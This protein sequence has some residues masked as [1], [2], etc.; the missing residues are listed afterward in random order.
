MDILTLNITDKY[1]PVGNFWELD[2]AFAGRGEWETVLTR[3]VE[4]TETVEVTEEELQ[5]EEVFETVNHPLGGAFWAKGAETYLDINE[6]IRVATKDDTVYVQGMVP[7]LPEEWVRGVKK[8]GVVTFPLQLITVKDDQK[9]FL[10]GLSGDGL[11]MAPFTM[12]FD[13]E[14]KSY[15]AQSKLVVNNSDLY[16]DESTVWGYYTGVYVGQRPEPVKLPEYIA[17]NEIRQMPY[18]GVYDNGVRRMSTAGI[19]NVVNDGDDFYFQGLVKNLPDAWVK[20]TTDNTGSVI[21]IPEG[22][23]VGY[24]AYGNVFAVGDKYYKKDFLVFGESSDDADSVRIAYD[25]EKPTFRLMS[26]FYASR[27]ADDRTLKPTLHTRNPL[28]TAAPRGSL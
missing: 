28:G 2:S 19:V 5:N 17:E 3:Y 12:L 7:M 20:G 11:N 9:Y 26:N 27:K 16:Y 1:A 21:I 22:Q 10:S 15:A 14:L 18:E 8:N 6:Q 24:D 4:V 25:Y 13:E 23:Y